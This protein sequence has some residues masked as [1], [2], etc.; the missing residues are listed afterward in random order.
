MK[1]HESKEGG[2]GG[3]GHKK[4]PKSLKPTQPNAKL[5]RDTKVTTYHQ[6]VETLLDSEQQLLC[7][8]SFPDTAV[9]DLAWC[10]IT[11][12]NS[13]SCPSCVPF[14]PFIHPHP[15][16]AVGVQAEKQKI[17]MCKHCL[18]IAKTIFLSS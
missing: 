1:P 5:S 17:L 13:V 2:E 8:N 9:C 11:L 6:Q 3:G 7:N 10:D 14:H 18:V 16:W 12:V 4:N 15:N